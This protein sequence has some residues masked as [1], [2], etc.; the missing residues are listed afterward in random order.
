M[1]IGLLA[2]THGYLDEAIFKYLEDCDEVWHAGDLGNLTVYERLAGFKPLQAVYGNIDGKAVRLVCPEDLWLTREGLTIWMTHIGGY[3][4]RYN[5]RV[6]HILSERPAQLFVCGHSH[7]LKVMRDPARQNMLCL[8]PGA[9]GKQGFHR[10]RTLLKFE[11]HQQQV[12]NMQAVELGKR[13]A[14]PLP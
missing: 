4:P 9:A 1:K 11:L 2:D 10:M 13:A 3:P 14:L 7:I 6:M 12:F 8:N 5:P